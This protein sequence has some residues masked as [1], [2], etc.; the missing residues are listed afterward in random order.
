MK[1]QEAKKIIK[2]K[3]YAN[4]PIVQA[5][6]L[7][8]GFKEVARKLKIKSVWS[9]YKWEKNNKVPPARVLQLEKLTKGKIT[10]YQLDPEL[11]P[12]DD[13]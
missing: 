3:K 12:L 6:F 10:R 11:Y 1:K 4:T 5:I 2:R 9:V 7:A 13:I 8:G